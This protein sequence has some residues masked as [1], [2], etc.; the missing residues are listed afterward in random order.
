M[1]PGHC[2]QSA[3]RSRRAS[4]TN[5]GRRLSRQWRPSTGRPPL[6]ALSWKK[7]KACPQPVIQHADRGHTCRRRLSTGPQGTHGPR[8]DLDGRPR[9][10][11][12]ESDEFASRAWTWA[13]AKLRLTHVFFP[14]GF[15]ALVRAVVSRPR[16]SADR[17][18]PG[19]APTVGG[20]ES[21]GR[22]GRGGQEATA[23][24]SYRQRLFVEHDLGESSGST[25]D[26]GAELGIHGLNRWPVKC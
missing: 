12:S 19:D 24:T 25:V 14:L 23:R 16:R 4:R 11:G 2:L 20:W 10:G 7:S 3:R 15:I 18:F 5:S 22:R 1:G 17:R 26:V 8:S 6:S 9:H 21:C 13:A